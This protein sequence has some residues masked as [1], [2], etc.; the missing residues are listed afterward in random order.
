MELRKQPRRYHAPLRQR[1]I[2]RTG[3]PAIATFAM[4]CCDACALLTGLEGRRDLAPLQTG[5]FASS[6]SQ[7]GAL[8]ANSWTSSG[9]SVS[10]ENASVA[11]STWGASGGVSAVNDSTIGNSNGGT[12]GIATSLGGNGGDPT[13]F[14]TDARSG[15]AGGD[16]GNT[17]ATGGTTARFLA[18]GGSGTVL[19]TNSCFGLDSSQCN[20]AN[21]CLT[22]SLSGSRFAMGRS[23]GD[24]GADAFELGAADELPEH[25]VVLSPFGLDK[26]EVTVGRFRRFVDAY[27]GTLPL[28]GDGANPNIPD[29][30]W[31]AE[32]NSQLPA[33]Q[34]SLRAMLTS[35][36]ALLPTWTADVGTNECRPINRVT[37]Y[38]AFA[39]CIWDGGRLPTEAEWEFAAAGGAENRLFPWG[40]DSPNYQRASYQCG[41][42]GSLTCTLDDIPTVGSTRPLGDGLFGHSDLAGSMGEV[43]RDQY[44]PYTSA[45]MHDFAALAND[46]YTNSTPVRGGGYEA[47]SY[48]LRA[49][50]RMNSYRSTPY[51]AVGMRCARDR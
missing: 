21:P 18:D 28:P 46:I 44:A 36:T 45:T 49:T 9:G 32:W 33:N 42:A 37:W 23:E 6:V 43:T 39:F 50:A 27:T 7:G 10:A 38:L 17:S 14:G 5:G 51:L 15:G 16:R 41:F 1:R 29:S 47:S 35:D 2:S 3:I 40:S 22:I 12:A 48:E 20:G 34:E 13:T 31:H 11:T 8:A 19:A 30:G 25:P 24:A 4:L 26:Y